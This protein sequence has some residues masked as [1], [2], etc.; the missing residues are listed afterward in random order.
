MW[1]GLILVG[2]TVTW[3]TRAMM[4][5]AKERKDAILSDRLEKGSQS[6]ATT[7]ENY[8]ISD[9][10]NVS[11]DNLVYERVN[12]ILRDNREWI[13]PGVR[14]YGRMGQHTVKNV[15]F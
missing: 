3:Y 12:V 8:S 13:V 11:V 10:D 2:I 15:I 1:S 6:S 14:N 5:W 7:H 4:K 9:F